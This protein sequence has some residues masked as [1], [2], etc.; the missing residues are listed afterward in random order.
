MYIFQEREER[1]TILEG[2]QYQNYVVTLTK[3]PSVVE[4]DAELVSDSITKFKLTIRMAFKKD[5][6]VLNLHF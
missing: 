6:L 1:N 2:K 4:V 3:D 5:D